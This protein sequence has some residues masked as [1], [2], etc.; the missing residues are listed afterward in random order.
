MR[1][2]GPPA[3]RF[4]KPIPGSLEPSATP[5]KSCDEGIEPLPSPP[6]VSRRPC[7]SS[8]DSQARPRSLTEAPV[9]GRRFD[10][11][12]RLV[13]GRGLS[14]EPRGRAWELRIQRNKTTGARTREG[15]LLRWKLR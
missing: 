1:P 7:R 4:T 5:L 11:P 6:A 8:P 12:I 15:S 10:E 14:E 3:K 13:V 9:Y 2:P